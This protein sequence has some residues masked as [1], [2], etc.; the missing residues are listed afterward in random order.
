MI[1]FYS[2]EKD[3]GLVSLPPFVHG[4]KNV[5]YNVLTEQVSLFDWLYSLTCFV[6]CVL[7]LLF[8]RLQRHKF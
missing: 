1:N 3:M 7:Q 6:M 8:L 4:K 5:C 2:L